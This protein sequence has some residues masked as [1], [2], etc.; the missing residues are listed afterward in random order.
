ME[1]E[2]TRD[3]VARHPLEFIEGG[4]LELYVRVRSLGADT[5]EIVSYRITLFDLPDNVNGVKTLRFDRPEG[6]PGREG[7]DNDLNDNPQHPWSHLHVN[8]HDRGNEFRM[9]TADVNPLLV[10]R[11]IDHWYYRTFC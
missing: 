1:R 7:W 2:L 6:K 4:R 9:P 11:S 5:L 3:P 10:I 8:F